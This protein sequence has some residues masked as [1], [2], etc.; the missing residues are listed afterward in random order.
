MR[1][2]P[3]SS[4]ERWRE[5]R[6]KHKGEK[7]SRKQPIIGT[8]DFET[9]PFDETK[10]GQEPVYPFLVCVD[11]G[12]LEKWHLWR[13]KGE[14]LYQFLDR[15]MGRLRKISYKCILYAH[16][17]GRFDMKFLQS[18]LRGAVSH[19]GSA[20]M[21]VDVGEVQ[22]R[23]SLHIIPTPL[24]AYKKDEFNYSWLHENVREDHKEA[25]IK[26]CYADCEYARQMILEFH[27]RYG[28]KI[29]IGQAAYSNLTKIKKDKGVEIVRL[30]EHMDGMIRGIDTDYRNKDTYGKQT[31]E[32]YFK[33]GR[34]ECLAG[35]GIFNGR[36]RL[37][38]VNSMYPFV[39]VEYRHP[40][41]GNFTSHID[42]PNDNTA[43]IHLRC[44]S[45]GAFLKYARGKLSGETEYGEFKVTKH[46][47]DIALE[48]GLVRG[49]EI[50]ECI[51][52][53]QFATFGDFINP[54]YDKRQIVKQHMKEW[55]DAGREEIGEDWDRLKMDDL[56]LKLLMNNAYG[57][58]AQNPRR[59]REQV[60]MDIDATIDFEY[61][62]LDEVLG[63]ERPFKIAHRKLDGAW[64]DKEKM[65][66]LRKP[67]D[68]LRFYNVATGASI[69]GAA[70]SVLLRALHSSID[71]I[72]CDTD[73]IICR[74][75]GPN[76]DLDETRLGAWK[77][78]CELD[79]PVIGG[80]KLYA[81]TMTNGKVK[82]RSKGMPGLTLEDLHL[83][84][85]GKSVRKKNKG[86]NIAHD[87]TQ[88][89]IIRELKRTAVKG[90]SLFRRKNVNEQVLEVA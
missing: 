28:D 30:S 82:V 74:E 42:L 53:D 15:F 3:K 21:R 89:Y 62:M 43:F 7:R 52:C 11:I 72:Y 87:M 5:Y 17:G 35:Y 4:T 6:L 39:M 2:E 85:Q 60:F 18:Y 14:D 9:N 26:Y 71:P 77:L 58:F 41:G 16:N 27:A 25:I 88:Q 33:G 64:N 78:E 90:P 44:Y 13:E 37:Y 55:K 54:L 23:D 70:R 68:R 65:Y 67:E 51:D 20:I 10:E 34:C 79:N 63:C 83:I 81:Y 40:I 19:K 66:E 47:Y 29:S 61:D 46:E 76:I 38:D 12:D 45:N 57:K 69:T 36:Y 73:S 75:M 50:I 86:V 32:G 22:L 84:V 59:F 80:K 31:S 24:K 48:L 49:V 1:V 56:F 8:F